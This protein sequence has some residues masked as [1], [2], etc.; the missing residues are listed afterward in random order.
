MPFRRCGTPNDITTLDFI[1][2][3]AEL[4][5]D[6]DANQPDIEKLRQYQ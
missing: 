6:A 4:V 2:H 5:N 1:N 3:A